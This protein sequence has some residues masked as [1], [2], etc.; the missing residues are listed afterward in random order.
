MKNIIG[1]SYIFFATLSIWNKREQSYTPVIAFA[2]LEGVFTILK[3]LI[4]R[5]FA[6][7]KL[8]LSDKK[9]ISESQ[10]QCYH[11]PICLNMQSAQFIATIMNCGRMRGNDVSAQMPISW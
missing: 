6:S 3:L 8:E 2:F 7:L 4:K 11:S 9:F 5:V 10:L 1:M